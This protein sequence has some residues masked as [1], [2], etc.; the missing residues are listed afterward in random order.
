MTG[1]AS[2]KSR[3]RAKPLALANALLVP[4]AVLTFV[5]SLSVYFLILAPAFPI[6]VT[7][8]WLQMRNEWSKP[9]VAVGLCTLSGFAIG[10]SLLFWQCVPQISAKIQSLL[11]V[12]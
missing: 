8:L 11:R 10:Y 2:K 9:E 1:D 4:I 5:P 12:G 7:V 6:I 3:I